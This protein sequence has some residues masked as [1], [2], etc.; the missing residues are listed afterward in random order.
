MIIKVFKAH[1]KD[2]WVWKQ[3]FSQLFRGEL[4]VLTERLY[5]P[6]ESHF[7]CIYSDMLEVYRSTIFQM[8]CFFNAFENERI[9]GWSHYVLQY[10]HVVVSINFKEIYWDFT[11]ML[12]LEL[13]KRSQLVFVSFTNYFRV[14]ILK[15]LKRNTMFQYRKK[16]IHSMSEEV[17]WSPRIM[18]SDFLW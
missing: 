5:W 17:T 13:K 10:R 15:F 2:W 18:I 3:I 12:C 6:L 4:S 8:F 1:Y 11:L 9:E 7:S 16:N 14:C